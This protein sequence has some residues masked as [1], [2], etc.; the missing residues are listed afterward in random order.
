[1]LPSLPRWLARRAARPLAALAL[2]AVL[3][4]GLAYVQLNRPLPK[5]PARQTLPAAL[6][7]PGPPPQLPWPR[8]GIAAVGASDL[9]LIATSPAERPLPMF[10]V[11]K[12]MTALVVLDDHPLR[13]DERGPDITVTDADVQAYQR[14]RAAQESV[15]AVAAGEKLSEYQALQALLIPSGNNIADILAVWDAGSIDAFV[16]KLNAKA[17]AL[18]M[19]QTTYADPSG[20]SDQTR[21]TPSDLTRQALIAISNPVIADIVSQPQAQLPVA[22]TVYNVDYSLG[23]GGIAGIKTGSSPEGGACF[24]F[25]APFRIAART[26]TVVGA[27]M[28]LPTLD[29]A[30]RTSRTLIEAVHQSLRVDQ[31]V[32]AGAVVGR[33]SAPWGPSADLVAAAPAVIVEWPGARVE[34]VLHAPDLRPPLAAGSSAGWL[35]VRL[36]DQVLRAPV[37]AAAA[38][39]PPGRR[40]KLTRI[41]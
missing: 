8:E 21:S 6:A 32:A 17:Q 19:K 7:V 22:G 34:R 14:R 13:R 27:V 40:W 26:V 29:D 16:Q 39:P 37:E 18:G 24:M 36:G 35:E 30:F 25:A 41:L 11:A 20:V 12:V 3:V 28:G 4:A 1:M 9:G 5:V 23:Q 33:Y 31:V 10:S 15:V 38:V 2:V